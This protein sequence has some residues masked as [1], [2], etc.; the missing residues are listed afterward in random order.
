MCKIKVPQAYIGQI[1]TADLNHENKQNLW[2]T[3][4]KYRSIYKKIEC[5]KL[6]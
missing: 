4:S 3:N 5:F 6:L 2:A 1:L